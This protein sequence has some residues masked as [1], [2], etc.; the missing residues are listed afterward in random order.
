MRIR[1]AVLLRALGACVLVVCLVNLLN[2]LS[3]HVGSSH[4][5]F[6]LSS[7]RDVSWLRYFIHSRLFGINSGE[8]DPRINISDFL[9]E[10]SDDL[11]E[12]SH[13]K[14][15]HVVQRI[16]QN[17]DTVDMITKPATPARYSKRIGGMD[18]PVPLWQRRLSDRLNRTGAD[19]IDDFDHRYFLVELLQVRI[20]PEDR[21]KWTIAELK[22]WM[23]FLFLAGVEHIYI[24]DHYKNSSERLALSLQRYV[25]LGLVTYLDWG[26]IR[27]PMLAQIKCYQHI[28]NAHKYEAIWQMA[29]DMD[30]YPFS[31]N[32]K[33]EDFL[34]RFLRTAPAYVTEI[35][36]ANFLMLGQGDRSRDMVIDRISRMTPREANLLVKPIYRPER[37]Q[38][39][40]HRN[41]LIMGKRVAAPS[42]QMRM[43]HYWGARV[44]D[45]GADTQHTLDI[46]MEMTSMRDAWA[47]RVRE[48]LLVFGEHTAFNSSTGP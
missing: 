29:L 28:I 30:E 40:V 25:T 11:I 45:W 38:A 47:R 33:E 24:C 17:N 10:S 27:D 31:V 4:A 20:Y 36:L 34:F 8:D 2:G 1:R 44:Q 5:H 46:T 9:Y 39:N 19:F 35:S 23:H 7:D 37:V 48:S 41:H 14:H 18:L 6:Q 15:S 3:P 12:I 22:Q 32:D 13:K 16:L 42:N 21:A 43:L 26:A